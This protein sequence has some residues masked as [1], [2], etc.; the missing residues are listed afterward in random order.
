MDHCTKISYACGNE[1]KILCHGQNTTC[2][3]KFHQRSAGIIGVEDIKAD[4]LASNAYCG[5]S[6]KCIGS[7]HMEVNVHSARTAEPTWVKC[8]VAKMSEAEV[9]NTE[10]WEY[11]T[12]K[13]SG[14]TA[15][16]D[17]QL[18]HVQAGVAPVK[19]YCILT[20]GKDG[21]R[22]TKPT[23][24]AMKNHH[25]SAAIGLFSGRLVLLLSVLLLLIQHVSI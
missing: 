5:P 18:A 20:N 13:V 10:A 8:A 9:N 15:A 6:G 11:C 25:Q 7:L 24:V 4:L 16:C 17:V 3:G 1:L 19:G 21:Q 14:S 22:L 23:W 12:N 2:E